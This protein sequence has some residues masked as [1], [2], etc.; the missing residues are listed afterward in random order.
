MNLNGLRSSRYIRA[1][2]ILKIPVGRRRIYRAAELVTYNKKG[3]KYI[4]KSG[5]SLWRIAR[6][7][8]VTIQE[9]MALN[10][11]KS[12]RLRVG[13]IIYIPFDITAS[14]KFKLKTY[15]VKKGDTPYDIAKKFGMKL[16]T[17]LKINNLTK[18]S[19]IF[20]GQIVMVKAE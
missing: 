16:S 17:F 8:G 9:I 2:W 1:G 19:L 4:V 6:R 12:P 13:Q 15:K 3:I 20:P 18:K 14:V 11:L 10:G 7:F 5:D